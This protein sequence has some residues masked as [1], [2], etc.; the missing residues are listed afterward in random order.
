V[1]DEGKTIAVVLN[2]IVLL[3]LLQQLE[4]VASKH[5]DAVIHSSLVSD[6]R[7]AHATV[8]FGSYIER[9]GSGRIF[10]KKAHES[11]PDFLESID[12]IGKFLS[13][14]FKLVCREVAAC[15]Q[16]V[17]E[18]LRLWKAITLMF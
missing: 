6:V 16:S 2:D 7:R 5:R 3:Y 4:L 15:V 10:T 11:C 8:M 14:M 13:H 17:P 18:E 12:G 9:E 1:N